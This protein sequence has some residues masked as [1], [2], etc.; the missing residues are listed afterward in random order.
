VQVK[1]R[2]VNH[3][4]QV[5][6]A[7]EGL[8]QTRLRLN[9][10]SSLIAPV[11]VLSHDRPGYLGKTLMTLLKWVQGVLTTTTHACPLVPW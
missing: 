5:G 9:T 7:C 11:V 8:D 3:R 10:T 1:D 6:A 4:G 2:D